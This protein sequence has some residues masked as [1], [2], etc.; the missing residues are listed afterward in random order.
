ME[1][2]NE[3]PAEE[4]A[5]V[6]RFAKTG[7]KGSGASRG[8]TPCNTAQMGHRADDLLPEVKQHLGIQGD[9]RDAEILG[10]IRRAQ[11]EIELLAGRQFSLRSGELNCSRENHGTHYGD[12]R[13]PVVGPIKIVQRVPPACFPL[14]N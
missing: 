1:D 5:A 3:G 13:D 7:L 2:Q 11:S 12:G 14:L 8:F 10:N 9:E 4:L 6:V